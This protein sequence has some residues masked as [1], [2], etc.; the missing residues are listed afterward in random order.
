MGLTHLTS[1]LIRFVWAAADQRFDLLIDCLRVYQ[2]QSGHVK[3]APESTLR[4]YLSAYLLKCSP[5]Y[6]L[7][8][9]V[10]VVV[11]VLV[12]SKFLTRNMWPPG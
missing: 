1:T 12:S 6:L 5:T 2:G 8:Y 11:V 10:V 3:V 9:F 4:T 7:T